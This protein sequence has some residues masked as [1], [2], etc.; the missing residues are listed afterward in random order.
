MAP[1]STR[2]PASVAALAA[3]R[4]ARAR[5]SNMPVAASSCSRTLITF[6]SGKLEASARR[7]CVSWT[8]DALAMATLVSTAPCSA[9]GSTITVNEGPKPPKS[10]R[11]RTAMRASISR[12]STDRVRLSPTF[13]PAPRA[14]SASR[15]TSGGP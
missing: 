11:L 6:T 9:A 14:T 7:I 12:P 13:S 2:S 10:T 8:L 4:T 1:A 3:P 5:R 15:A